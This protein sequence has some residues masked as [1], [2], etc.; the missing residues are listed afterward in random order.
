MGADWIVTPELC[1]SGYLFV[2]KMDT[3]WIMPYPDTWTDHF[4]QLAAELRVTLFLAH[5]ERDGDSGKLY[6]AVVVIGSDGAVLGKHRKVNV[7]A[8]CEGWSTRGDDPS[9]ILVDSLAVGVLICAD[10]W[11]PNV[12]DRLKDQGAQL[13]VSSAS[14]PPRPHGPEG[15]WENRSRETGLPLFVCNRTGID[16]TLDCR[17][18]QSVVVN[19]GE[20]LMA[21]Q[22]EHSAIVLVDWDPATNQFLG[23]KSVTVEA[24]ADEP[25]ART[26]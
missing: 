11:S 10:S 20:V 19:N 25:A 12:A 26:S 17:E 5:Q 13:L 2:R 3:N 4:R 1:L 14:W 8:S 9:P 24:V 7:V 22:S 16:E 15:C 18:S 6:N 21:F 23:H